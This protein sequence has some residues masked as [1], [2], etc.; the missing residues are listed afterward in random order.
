MVKLCLQKGLKAHVMDVTE[1]QFLP[2]SFDAAYALNSFLHV[3]DAEFY[4]AMANVKKVMKPTGLFYLGVYGGYDFEGIWEEDSYEPKRFF[5]LR[6][7]QHLQELVSQHFQLLA[8]KSMEVDSDH[9]H[10]QSLIL[11]KTDS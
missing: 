7:D 1:L 8:F 5:S 6:T 4:A 10:F 9:S 11:R 3:P 2:D